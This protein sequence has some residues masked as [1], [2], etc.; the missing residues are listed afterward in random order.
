MSTAPSMEDRAARKV[1]AAPAAV[2][3]DAVA[4]VLELEEQ[5]TDVVVSP[6]PETRYEMI[7]TAAYFIAE[8]RG[9]APGH[10]LADW[11][12]AERAVDCLFRE[13]AGEG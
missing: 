6:D 4:E 9:F 1:S 13:H 8:Q 11:L 10:D 2:T 3:E 5:P 7:C 12:A